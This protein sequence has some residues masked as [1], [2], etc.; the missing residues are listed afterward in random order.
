MIN[1]CHESR[2]AA[3]DESEYK[4]DFANV[5]DVDREEG[6]GIEAVKEKDADK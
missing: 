6:D 2:E 1:K 4:E 5:G 3:S